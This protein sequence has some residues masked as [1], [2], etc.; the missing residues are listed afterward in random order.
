[1]QIISKHPHLFA[2]KSNE[3]NLFFA[4]RIVAQ[5]HRRERKK[6]L[7]EVQKREARLAKRLKNVRQSSEQVLDLVSK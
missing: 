3:A 7:K 4:L 2:G 6:F 1:M 5:K